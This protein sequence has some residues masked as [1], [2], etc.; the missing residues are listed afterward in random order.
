[1]TPIMIRTLQEMQSISRHWEPG[2]KIG[3]IPTMGYLHEGHI[4]LVKAAEAECDIIV[5]S[6]YVN[7]SQFGP[8]E[9]FSKYPR[10]LEH[11]LKQLSQ[12][13]VDY[14]FFPSDK[15]M[16]PDN[17]RTWVSVDG[18]S[19]VLCGKS[20]PGHFRGVST[21]VLKLINLVHPT[22]MYM[23]LKDYQQIVVLEKMI[24]DLHL[25]TIIRRCPIVRE[26]DGLAMSSRNKYLDADERQRALSLSNSL[27]VVREYVA[28]GGSDVREAKGMMQA[29]IIEAEGRID[30]IEIADS[31]TLQ[32]VERIESGNR[33]LVAVYFG[34][35]RLIDN[36]EL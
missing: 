29:K 3:F 20:R 36:M 13:K 1:M 26:S 33:A 5:V 12:C 18:L 15:E 23:G 27:Q 14:L 4:S 7:P 8:N 22:Y 6:I 24:S 28:A 19:D 11:D 9:D 30:Y 34:K 17:Y 2:K 21:I 35:T 31:K 10:D 32:P 25:P 16:Y